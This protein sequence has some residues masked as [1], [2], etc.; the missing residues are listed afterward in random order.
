[1]VE[2]CEAHG[3]A[4]I[5]GYF[6]DLLVRWFW[7][8]TARLVEVC[9]LKGGLKECG[10]IASSFRCLYDMQAGNSNYTTGSFVVTTAFQAVLLHRL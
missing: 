8:R 9:W 5:G 3:I 4:H 6:L 2:E 10:R 7:M 1:M